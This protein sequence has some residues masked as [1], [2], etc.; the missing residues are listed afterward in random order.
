MQD[1][2]AMHR[3]D[4]LAVHVVELHEVQP[5]LR[6]DLIV[7]L[8]RVTARRKVWIG[9]DEGVELLHATPKPV[10]DC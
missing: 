7:V 3:G 10:R 9:R 8:R 1:V 2:K 5:I 4:H 6:V